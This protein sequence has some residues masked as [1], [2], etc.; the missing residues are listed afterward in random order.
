MKPYSKI[1]IAMLFLPFLAGCGAFP[2]SG[3]YGKEFKNKSV[4]RYGPVDSGNVLAVT[5]PNY[6]AAD[7]S[8]SLIE[9]ME[10]KAK[11]SPSTNWPDKA[12]ADI[13]TINV[14]DTIQ[15]AIF[16][17]REFCNITATNN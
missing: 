12:L 10:D 6:Y 16:E 17:S 13:I 15:V 14:G 7:I 4:E 5:E 11:N 2:A 8:D 3:P 1:L 9:Y